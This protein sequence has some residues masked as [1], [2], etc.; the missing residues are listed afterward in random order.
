[1]SSCSRKSSLC[2]LLLMT[3]LLAALPCRV[4]AQ[5][6]S[7]V[8]ARYKVDIWRSQEEVKLAFTSNLLQTRDG[9]LW[10][11]SRVW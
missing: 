3:L 11:R 7:V 2:Y 10:L 5:Q 1:M 4:A 9:Y 6:A 8:L